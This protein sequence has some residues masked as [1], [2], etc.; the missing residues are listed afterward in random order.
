MGNHEKMALESGIGRSQFQLWM[1]NG[2]EVR[3][4]HMML[5]PHIG[6]NHK[7]G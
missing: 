7:S 6:P 3:G 2:G 4:S 1:M 5:S